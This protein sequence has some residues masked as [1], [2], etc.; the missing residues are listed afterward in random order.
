MDKKE[1]L[2][3]D[4]KKLVLGQERAYQKLVE[5]KRYKNS[6]LIVSR[7]GKVIEIPPEEIPPTTTYHYK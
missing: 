1:E 7:N 4:S 3:E 5:F 2:L 6:P